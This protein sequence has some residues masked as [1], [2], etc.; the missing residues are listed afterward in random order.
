MVYTS[1]IAAIA[2]SPSARVDGFLGAGHVCTVMGIGDYEPIVERF[3]GRYLFIG[4]RFEVVE[5]E[6]RP[7][8]PILIEFPSL[9]QAHRW[10]GSEEFREL[11]EVRLRAFRSDAV[12]MEGLMEGLSGRRAQT[13]SSASSRVSAALI[14]ASRVSRRSWVRSSAIS[15]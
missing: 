1:P 6:W 15:T 4:G 13:C 9:E 11:Q 8:F 12:F 5:G 14:R 2:A 7:T 3:G 10:Y